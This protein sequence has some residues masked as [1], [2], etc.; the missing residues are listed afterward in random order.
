[1]FSIVPIGDVRWVSRMS[2]SKPYTQFLLHRRDSIRS[3]FGFELSYV[4]WQCIW[5]ESGQFANRGN[6]VG[7]YSM[8]RINT[9]LPF[10]VGNVRIEQIGLLKAER[11]SFSLHK[12]N[13]KSRGIDFLLTFEEWYKIW[14]DSGHINDRGT[15][16]GQYCMARKGDKGPYAVGNVGIVLHKVNS[17]EGNVGRTHSLEIRKKLSEFALSRVRKRTLTGRFA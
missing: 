14:G 16:L 3:G 6:R 15:K 8:N 5:N 13:A 9:S 10:M 1:M 11:H 12:S 4:E 2:K 7:Q 17:I